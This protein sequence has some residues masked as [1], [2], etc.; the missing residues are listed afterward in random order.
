MHVSIQPFDERYR[1]AI[2]GLIVAIQQ[3]EFGIAITHDEQPDLQDIGGF[4]LT[5]SGGF[6]LALA[7]EQVV[8]CIALKDIGSGQA[9]LRKMFVAESHRGAGPGVARRLLAT[10][11]AHARAAGVREIF[12]GTTAKFVAAHR[13]YEKNG[14]LPI[15]AAAL[16]ESFPRMDVDTRFY[17]LRLGG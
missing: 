12:L 15:A 10:L 17:R 6:W 13:F 3:H 1:A 8:G 2:T 4:Y 9:A 11:L 14:F 16:P 7:G 5:G